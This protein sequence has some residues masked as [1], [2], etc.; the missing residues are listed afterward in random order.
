MNRNV[1]QSEAVIEL[2]SGVVI[3]DMLWLANFRMT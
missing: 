2:H 1:G 3:S